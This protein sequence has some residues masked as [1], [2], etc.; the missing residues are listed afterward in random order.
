MIIQSVS[1]KRSGKQKRQAGDLP[2]REKSPYSSARSP[3]R[4]TMPARFRM[5]SSSTCLTFTI[6]L[7]VDN[8]Y[9]F[10]T[11]GVLV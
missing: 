10:F 4:G 5:P 1:K 9:L 6:L 8:L 7:L 3:L 2:Q 11:K